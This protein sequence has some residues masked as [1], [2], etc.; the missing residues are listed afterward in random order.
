MAES[1]GQE[2][3]EQPTGKKIDDSRGEGQVAKSAELNSLAIFGVGIIILFMYKDFVGSRISGFSKKIF[4]SL[5]ELELTRQ[6]I[7]G[8]I[9]EY[10]LFILVTLAPFFVSL[11]LIAIITGYGQAGFKI[12]PKVFKPKFS[13][14]NPI[15]GLKNHFFSMN[16]I[17]ELGKSSFKFTVIGLIAYF[18]LKNSIL[19]SSKLIH[20]SIREILEFMT[21]TSFA[22]IWKIIMV[23]A[24]IAFADF[25]YQKM[26]HKK[27]LMMTK[28]EVKEENKNTEGD[29]QIKS[30]IKSKQFEMSRRRM[31]AEV[32]KADVVITNPTHVAVALKYEL[33]KDKAPKVVAKGLDNIAQKIKEIAAENNI[34]MHEDVFLARTL[35]KHCDI[36]DEVPE[37]LF[38][39]VAQILA[40]VYKLKNKRKKSIV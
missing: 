5:N 36:G 11:V 28:Q 16:P 6:N 19:F 40:Y 10:F 9:L 4:S 37:N 1:D 12:T 24:V 32:P 2:K 27:E 22:L 15:N 30:R 3:T 33:G 34:H 31:M 7:Q 29:P 20:Y 21:E 14:I 13:K 23:Y 35:Y 18:E 25:V 39:A 26:K 17:F 38:R 8:T